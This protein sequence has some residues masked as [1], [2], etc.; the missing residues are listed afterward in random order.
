MSMSEIVVDEPEMAY[1]KGEH[2]EWWNAK[3]G[4]CAITMLPKRLREITKV[5][6]HIKG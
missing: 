3:E 6:N 4:T 5:L 2:C 1:C